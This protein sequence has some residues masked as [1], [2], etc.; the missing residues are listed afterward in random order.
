[1]PRKS[2]GQGGVCSGEVLGCQGNLEC[3]N[4]C[5]GIAEAIVEVGFAEAIFGSGWYLW[6]GMVGVAKAML[7]VGVEV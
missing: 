5:E 6:W 7:N 2:T 4:Q 1:M 3:G